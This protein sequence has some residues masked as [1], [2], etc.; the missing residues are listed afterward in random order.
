MRCALLNGTA[1]D[2]TGCGLAVAHHYRTINHYHTMGT[3]TEAPSHTSS[4]PLPQ[5]RLGMIKK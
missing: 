5:A 2:Q 4:F 3:G 1:P